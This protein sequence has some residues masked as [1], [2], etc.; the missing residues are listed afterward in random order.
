MIWVGIFLSVIDWM[1]IILLCIAAKRGDKFTQD[2]LGRELTH[3]ASQVAQK[4]EQSSI[5]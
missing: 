3:T 2:A 1:F 5:G 4:T